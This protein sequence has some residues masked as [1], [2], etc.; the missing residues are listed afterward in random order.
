[1]Q[2]ETDV[3]VVGFLVVVQGAD[4]T[5]QVHEGQ[6]HLVGQVLQGRL[7][8]DLLDH[9][10]PLFLALELLGRV[11]GQFPLPQVDHEIDQG[12]DIIP[13]RVLGLIMRVDAREQVLTIKPAILLVGHVLAGLL[14]PVSF[15]LPEIDHM[16]DMALVLDTH[17]KVLGLDVPVDESCVVEDFNAVDHLQAEDEHGF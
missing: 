9:S 10:V 12:L 11:P 17:D 4:V 8:L 3:V 5:Q 13:P 15:A 16:Q 14:I 7:L 6:W 1:M 2:K